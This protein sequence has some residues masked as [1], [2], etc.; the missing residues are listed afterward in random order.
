MLAHPTAAGFAPQLGVGGTV[1]T[2]DCRLAVT[3][4][5]HLGSVCVNLSIKLTG[6]CVNSSSM[7]AVGGLVS[8]QF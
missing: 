6:Q 7:T 2:S 4:W 1:G 5:V 3:H 8:R